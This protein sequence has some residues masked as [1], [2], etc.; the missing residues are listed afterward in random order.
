MSNTK[1]LRITSIE[2]TIEIIVNS[3]L[4]AFGFYPVGLEDRTYELNVRIIFKE[5]TADSEKSS[6]VHPLQ[7]EYYVREFLRFLER[8]KD[9]LAQQLLVVEDN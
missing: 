6:S 5:K 9:S 1:K 8:H 2:E 4:L 7:K 3:K